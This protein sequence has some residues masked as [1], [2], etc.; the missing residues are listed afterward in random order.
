MKLAGFS[1]KLHR[2]VIERELVLRNL[3][4]D[5]LFVTGLRDEGDGILSALEPDGRRSY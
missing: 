5:G 2:L 1:C 3:N 4:G